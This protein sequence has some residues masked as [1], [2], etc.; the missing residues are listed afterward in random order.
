MATDESNFPIDFVYYG[1]QT[2]RKVKG[3]DGVSIQKETHRLIFT[4]DNPF[5]FAKA[6][7]KSDE[8]LIIPTD[9][10]LI[11]FGE[12]TIDEGGILTIQP[13]AGLLVL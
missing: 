3:Q 7:I 8:H 11:V 1:R 5:G 10:Q 12:L 6:H 9:F 13:G 4:N 2:N